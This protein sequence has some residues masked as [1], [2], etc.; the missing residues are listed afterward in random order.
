MTYTV[1]AQ[2]RLITA[3]QFGQIVVR[4]NPDGSLVR[5]KDVARIELGAVNY[6]QVAR[7]NGKPTCIIVVFQAPGSNAIAVADGVQKVMDGMKQRFP[8]DL[9]YVTSLDTTRP[10]REGIREIVIT[11][12]EAMVLVIFVVYLFLTELE[13]DIDSDDR[14]SGFAHRN[15]CGFSVPVFFHQYLVSVRTSAGHRARGRRRHRGG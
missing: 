11:L 10:V 2:G 5:L 9:D 14:C 12:C 15:I 4:S 7:M 13:S 3:D 8:S 1:R 6:Q